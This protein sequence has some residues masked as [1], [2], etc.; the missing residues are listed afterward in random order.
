MLRATVL[1]KL[2]VSLSETLPRME[3]RVPDWFPGNRACGRHWLSSSLEHSRVPRSLLR[4]GARAANG[5][6]LPA[7]CLC[8]V[9]VPLS[10]AL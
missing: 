5:A 4:A 10:S 2:R 3:R 7:G 9:L 1:E 8:L 6:L